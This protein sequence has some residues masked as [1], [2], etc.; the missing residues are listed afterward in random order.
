MKKIMLVLH[1]RIVIRIK[2]NNRYNTAVYMWYWELTGVRIC[3]SKLCIIIFDV[4]KT[5]G[6]HLSYS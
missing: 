2:W 5:K 1:L 6:L 3:E 4:I